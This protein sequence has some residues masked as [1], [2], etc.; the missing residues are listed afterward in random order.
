MRSGLEV[1]FYM[2]WVYM[3]EVVYTQVWLTHKVG[4]RWTHTRGGFMHNVDSY[5]CGGLKHEVGSANNVG[6][7]TS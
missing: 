5:T 6:S 1:A 4:L 3:H 7:Y 2:R